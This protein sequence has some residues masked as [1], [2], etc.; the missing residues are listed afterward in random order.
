MF[1]DSLGYRV[2]SD[3]MELEVIGDQVLPSTSI[4]AA[5]LNSIESIAARP[6]GI[7]VATGSHDHTIKLWDVEE[8]KSTATLQGHKYT[9]LDTGRVFGHWTMHPM[10]DF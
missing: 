7:E 1:M 6:D 2:V 5:H 4:A 3:I 9:P 8:A 10:E